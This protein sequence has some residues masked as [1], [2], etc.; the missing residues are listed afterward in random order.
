MIS[1]LSTSAAILAVLL[2][3]PPVFGQSKTSDVKPLHCSV[4][5]YRRDLPYPDSLNGSGIQGVVIVE[6]IIGEDGC[7][8]SVG[9]VRKLHPKLDQIARDTVDSWKFLPAMKDGKP[10]AVKIQIE[11]K[12]KDG[13]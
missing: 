5:K 1:R 3:S 2:G 8:R 12:F 7:T 11:V 13:A 10:V 6:A 4:E 9:V